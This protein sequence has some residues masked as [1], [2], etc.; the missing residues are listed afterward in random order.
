[1]FLTFTAY[2][3]AL[4]SE[5]PFVYAENGKAEDHTGDGG[6]G[7]GGRVRVRVRIRDRD[8]VRVRARSR[9]MVPSP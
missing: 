6:G 2:Y 3:F 5:G 4:P 1:M 8:R 7:G 9:A